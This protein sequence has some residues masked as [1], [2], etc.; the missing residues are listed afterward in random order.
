MAVVGFS[1]SPGK[2]SYTVPR[3]LIEEGY[4]IYPVN[5]KAPSTMDG[6]KVYQNIQEIDEEIDLVLIFRPSS[7]VLSIVEEALKREDIKGLWMQ[8]G[9]YD[10]LAKTLAEE[11]G[12]L[13]IQD[14]CI[15][16]E[17]KA[18]KN[19]QKK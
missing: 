7:E 8:E 9:I 16:K 15:F 4:T 11:K 1:S 18:L 14:R 19:T 12:L 10:S 5:P 13:V 3:Y 6:L 17:H 2:P